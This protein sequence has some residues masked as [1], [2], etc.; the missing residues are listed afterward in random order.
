MWLKWR[1]QLHCAGRLVDITTNSAAHNS[2][3][4]DRSCKNSWISWLLFPSQ[5]SA[6]IVQFYPF[7]SPGITR[8][9]GCHTVTATVQEIG[10]L[11][12]ERSG[13]HASAAH[14]P[15]SPNAFYCWSMQALCWIGLFQPSQPLCPGRTNSHHHFKTWGGLWSSFGLAGHY[16]FEWTQ[17]SIRI[18]Q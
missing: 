15:G 4:V 13:L 9:F 7:R 14:L 12:A 5:T 18:R 17:F 6:L 3:F 10:D 11:D 2:R 1:T 16:G 8:F